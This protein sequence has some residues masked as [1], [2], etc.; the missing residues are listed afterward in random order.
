MEKKKYIL[1]IN[2]YISNDKIIRYYNR[3][4]YSK[5]V[6]DHGKMGWSSKT[7][8]QNRFK[9][10]LN[11]GVSDGDRLLDFGCGIGNMYEYIED[12]V[13]RYGDI[14][15]TGVDINGDFITIAKNRYGDQYFK[16]INKYTDIQEKFDWCV[17]SGVFTVHTSTYDMY[18]TV[19]Y[20]YGISNNG[21]S[22]NLLEKGLLY[23]D[24]IT[25]SKSNISIR[26]YDIE[27]VFNHMKKSYNNVYKIKH[28][29]GNE[30]TFY[31]KKR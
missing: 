17:A 9:I 16:H 10:L 8:Q 24:E 27:K 20:L 1:P 7:G 5:S 14:K 12:N 23:K 15:Y 4:Y 22:F 19:D 11:I 28:K 25:D 31:I 3:P 2:E 18:D 6:T 30:Y 21:V 26:G 29:K 13:K